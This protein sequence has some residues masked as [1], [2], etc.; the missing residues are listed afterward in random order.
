MISGSRVCERARRGD[1]VASSG[2]SLSLSISL[3]DEIGCADGDD[4]FAGFVGFA[5]FAGAFF[6]DAFFAGFAFFADDAFFAGAF[7][8]DDAFRDFA[9]FDERAI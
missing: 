9:F 2:R 8:A 4:F 1:G 3:R 7:F 5:F 6:A